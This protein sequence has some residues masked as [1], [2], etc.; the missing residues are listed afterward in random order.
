VTRFRQALWPL[1]PHTQAKHAILRRYLDAWLPIMASWNGRV[2]YVD[3]FAG[4]GAYEGGE[5]G[6]PIVALKAALEHRHPITAELIYLFIEAD[7]HRLANLRQ[8][9]GKL[10]LR[11]NIDVH[12]HLGRFDETMSG[13]L[14][15][16]GQQGRR[17]APTF[18]FVDPFGWS[19][20]PFSVLQRLL[21][22]SHCELL[23][24]FM[25]EEINRFLGREEHA[26]KWTRLFGTED[27]RPIAAIQGSAERRQAIHDLYQRQLKQAG[28]A[29][30]VRSFEMR[31]RSNATDYF[32]F[33]ATNSLTGLE[34]MKDAM[35]AVDPAGA[36]RFSDATAPGQ[37]VLFEPE[38]DVT[39][40]RR[41]LQTQFAGRTVD[42]ADV[43]RFVIEETAFKATHLRRRV[44][45]PMERERPP[46]IEVPSSRPGR[47]RGQF[48]PG[49]RIR[50]VTAPATLPDL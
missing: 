45:A 46:L 3:G 34:K 13:V 50:F 23:I 26:E 27:W 4:P 49:T 41:H 21:A 40:L 8:E 9:I 6:S 32:L 47:R 44:L 42:I 20:T 30:Y 19:Q 28:R 38:P 31:N 17:L 35:W 5:P 2:I 10:P 29:T 37:T 16:L 36:F 15:Q 18:A 1:E 22:N 12:T 33:F 43:E 48:P 25:Y 11:P 24:N 39:L 14:D 7:E